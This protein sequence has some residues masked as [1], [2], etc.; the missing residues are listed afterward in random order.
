[1]GWSLTN[2]F[3]QILGGII[4]GHLAVIASKELEF[5]ALGHTIAGAVGGVL[6]GIFLQ[7]LAATMV[8]GTGEL[9]A[10][11]VADQVLVQGLTGIVAG[12]IVTLAAGIFK[13]S[14]GQSDTKDQ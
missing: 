4:G 13:Q 12:G 11:R 5:G 6:S 7:T 9:T 8:T 1:M 3:I 10:P 14:R 2:L